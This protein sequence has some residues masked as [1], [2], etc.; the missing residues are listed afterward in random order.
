MTNHKTRCSFK[1]VLF[2]NDGV[3]VDT[4]RLYFQAT[5]EILSTRGVRLGADDFRELVLTDN[6]G[7]W[8][9]IE[10]ATEAEINSLRKRRNQRY[11]ALLG[12]GV[13]LNTGVRETVQSLARTHTLGIVT[14]STRDHFELIHARTDIL[15]LFSFV[16]TREDYTRSKPHP[17]PYLLAVAKSGFEASECLAVEDSERGLISAHAAGVRCA[18]IPTEETRSSDFSKAS[19]ILK[20]F[21]DLQSILSVF[22]V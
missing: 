14:S 20:T 5:R 10:G 21:A 2:D 16:L 15:S 1:A 18:V 6:R 17:E 12:D 13:R 11:A 19:W 22:K 7:A 9:L 3:L 4:E 8:H